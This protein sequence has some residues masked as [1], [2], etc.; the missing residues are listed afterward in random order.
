MALKHKWLEDAQTE[1]NETLMYVFTSVVN[2][3]NYKYHVSQ[4]Q[5]Q[6]IK[7]RN[8]CFFGWEHLR[9]ECGICR[10]ENRLPPGKQN[11]CYLCYLCENK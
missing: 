2:L 9:I 4:K 5:E 3:I 1:L 8:K 11:L 6:E 10:G 7:V